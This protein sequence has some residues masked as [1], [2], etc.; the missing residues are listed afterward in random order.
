M[1]GR[2]ATAPRDRASST[3][4]PAAL[5][6]N[7]C[8]RRE[9]MPV[10]LVTQCCERRIRPR[11]SRRRVDACQ[12][13]TKPLTESVSNSAGHWTGRARVN[14][15]R[16]GRPVGG[17]WTGLRVPRLHRSKKNNKD[18]RFTEIQ[19]FRE[20]P[21]SPSASPSKRPAN[22]SCACWPARRLEPPPDL[23]HAPGRPLSAGIPRDPGRGRLLPRSLLHA[24][25]WRPR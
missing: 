5:P 1:V 10:D 6:I 22:R 4:T 12:G 2:T 20:S 25:A 19:V 16:Q 11:E 15:H 3:V 7:R 9:S 24:A 17:L 18:M 14:D 21:V 23:D 8:R 13:F